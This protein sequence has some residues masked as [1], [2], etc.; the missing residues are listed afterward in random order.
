MPWQ[1][2]HPQVARMSLTQVVSKSYKRGSRSALAQ[3]RG[4]TRA[5]R[6]GESGRGRPVVAAHRSQPTRARRLLR[7][8]I[9]VVKIFKRIGSHRYSTRRRVD[10]SKITLRIQ[11]A[12]R[13]GG[14][15]RGQ[16]LD[17][18]SYAGKVKLASV[19]L[20]ATETGASAPRLIHS[21]GADAFYLQPGL[22]KLVP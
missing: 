21:A 10:C 16:R 18:Q 9:V 19:C 2:A 12:A 20:E 8:E 14:P 7:G 4:L 15:D 17:Q 11:G 5:P 22:A 1:S 3:K 13:T 6:Q